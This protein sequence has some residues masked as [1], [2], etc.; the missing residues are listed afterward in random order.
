MAYCKRLK[1]ATVWGLLLLI[2][3]S[4][5]VPMIVV[6]QSVPVNAV[7]INGTEQG[8][9]KSMYKKIAYGAFENC[10]N[11][12]DKV[13]LDYGVVNGVSFNVGPFSFGKLG[14]KGIESSKLRGG[15]WF[16][17]KKVADTTLGL[18]DTREAYSVGGLLEYKLTSKYKD[19][20]IYCGENGNALM[21]AFV[22]DDEYLNLKDSHEDVFCKGDE[23]LILGSGSSASCHETFNDQK[24]YFSAPTDGYAFYDNSIAVADTS[25][26]DYLDKLVKDK[27]FAGDVPGGSLYELTD[28]EQYFLLNDTFLHVCAHDEEPSDDSS[29]DYGILIRDQQSGK[30]VKKYFPAASKPG[31]S[32]KFAIRKKGDAVVKMSCDEIAKTLADENSAEIKAYKEYIKEV[33]VEEEDSEPVTAPDDEIC[34]DNSGAVGWMVCPLIE[35]G[36]E[37]A[38]F[39]YNEI[40]A[41]F[42]QLKAGKMFERDGGLETVWKMFR[43]IA[44][45]VFIIFFLVV[46]FSQLTGIGIDNYGIKKILPKLIVVAIVMNISFL[47]CALAVDISNIIGRGLNE[48]FTS[49]AMMV[50][51]ETVQ[52]T[53][54]GSLAAGGL[55]GGGTVLFVLLTNP[56]VTFAAVAVAVGIAVLGIVVSL[57]VSIF[58]M[59]LALMVRNMGIVLLIA[60]SPV[61]IVCYMLPNMDKTAKRWYEMLKALLLVYP[62]CG[63]LIGAGKLAGRL[64]GSFE[65]PGFAVAGMVAEVIPFFMIPKIL[66]S[67]L[68]LMGNLGARLMATGRTIGKRG[69]GAVKGSINSSKRYQDWSNFNKEQSAYRNAVKVRDRLSKRS[70]LNEAQRNR[71]VRAQHAAAAYESGREKMY[72]ESFKRN[73]RDANQKEFA[74]ALVGRDA[75][76]A[77]VG[78]SSLISQGGIGEALEVLNDENLD[79]DKMDSKVKNDMIQAM[80][81]SGVDVMK[82]YSKYLASGGTASFK[83]WTS[84][85]ITAEHKAKDS[86]KGISSDAISYANY[87]SANGPSALNKYSKDE[88]EFV[89][90]NSTSIRR[91]M[92]DNNTFGTMLANAAVY[93]NDARAKTIAEDTIRKELSSTA[94]DRMEL[95]NLNLTAQMF[96]DMRER[97]AQA[98]YGGELARIQSERPDI[99]T[100]SDNA[101][102]AAKDSAAEALHTA[103]APQI[104]GIESDN[105]LLNQIKPGVGEAIGMQIGAGNNAGFSGSGDTGAGSTAT[106][107]NSGF[108][109]SGDTGAGSTATNNFGQNGGGS[110]V[111]PG[112]NQNYVNTG[113]SNDAGRVHDNAH[114]YNNNSN[115]VS[116]FDG[117]NSNTN[118]GS[119]NGGNIGST[120]QVHIFD[121]R[122]TQG[123][124]TDALNSGH[125]DSRYSNGSLGTHV[126]IGPGGTPRQ[127]GLDS[128]RGNRSAARTPADS[129]TVNRPNDSGQIGPPVG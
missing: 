30:L 117:N 103:F 35:A 6:V 64:L 62:I 94:N 101:V 83:E 119:N 11:D 54:S 125:V 49:M 46:I 110:S 7:K 78:L 12:A 65:T 61:A 63:A 32:A 38:S 34:M 93:S 126:P 28:L 108:S 74:N 15:K 5:L 122:P 66:K 115:G 42:L 96:G 113:A 77:T 56:V 14:Q 23:F 121:S 29:L 120:R 2:A 84:G 112:V 109:G 79:W 4:A 116:R 99:Y 87:L 128:A 81:A 67:S 123:V 25:Q 118:N 71:Y 98:I 72:T 60:V 1:T 92:K 106:N 51:V 53:V 9:R 58:F 95:K 3:C 70:N 100:G 20:K 129:S 36:S 50:P 82:G 10:I 76:R 52:P 105:R 89:R 69:A 73:T 18:F 44:N 68:Q 21:S 90:D 48:L 85:N 37:I 88:M 41:D 59:Y 91:G 124:E 102:A 39:M 17:E 111:D 47:L 16:A 19:G 86:E 114:H 104:A 22:D 75:Q 27:A 26:E 24:G 33:Q 57:G 80:G 107:S 45:V 127:N 8:D 97:T 13:N 55:I 40:E 31:K 43:D